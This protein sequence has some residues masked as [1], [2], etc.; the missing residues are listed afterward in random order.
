MME[1]MFPISNHRQHKFIAGLSMG[2]YGAM[3]IGLSKYNQFQKIAT[4]SGAVDLDG[5]IDLWKNQEQSGLMEKN[6]Y[7]KI[8]GDNPIVPANA[9]IR[10]LVLEAK[11]NLPDIYQACGTEDFLFEGNKKFHKFLV[12]NN[13]EHYYEETP[14]FAH[15]WDYWDLKIKEILDW[16]FE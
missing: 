14:G 5:I 4:L 15:T 13:I 3:K 12:E 2:G 11:D 9:D 8:F 6:L 16:M 1:Q 7:V 10:N